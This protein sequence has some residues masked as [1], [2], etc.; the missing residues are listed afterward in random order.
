MPLL[1]ALFGEQ[2]DGLWAGYGSLMSFELYNSS[3]VGDEYYFRIVYNGEALV[4]PGCTMSLCDVNT[5]MDST[6]W[7]QYD[8]PCTNEIV[9][10]TSSN[11][12]DATVSTGGW[13]GLCLMS[14]ALGGIGTYFIM[15]LMATKIVTAA[16]ADDDKT[17]LTQS[18]SQL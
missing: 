17:R 15:T 10:S 12:N 4:F 3:S 18:G 5:F 7:A 13:V 8:M 9:S 2:W 11:S 16:N 1:A 6:T 14:A